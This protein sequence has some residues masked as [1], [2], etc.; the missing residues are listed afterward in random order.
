VATVAAGDPRS[1]T[2][3]M[4]GGPSSHSVHARG[5]ATRENRSGR[6]E[7][8]GAVLRSTDR[9]GPSEVGGGA[10]RRSDTAAHTEVIFFLFAGITAFNDN[11]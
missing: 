4:G 9:L 5:L 3:P 2:K 10:A 7:C 8:Y 1:F 6:W 11:S